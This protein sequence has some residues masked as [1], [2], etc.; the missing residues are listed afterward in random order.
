MIAMRKMVS[1]TSDPAS[2]AGRRALLLGVAGLALSGL[3]L[4]GCTTRMA[5]VGPRLG[6]PA[7][8]DGGFILSDGARLPYRTWLPVG[9]PRVAV[10]ALHG[11]NDSRDAWA[12]PGPVFARAGMAIYAPDQRGFGAAPGRGLWPGGDVL[13]RDAAE[14]ARL[15]RARHPDVPLVLMGESMGG[16]VLMRLATLP[17]APPAARYVLSAPAV[18]SRA[19]MNLFLRVGLWAAATFVPGMTAARP[20]PPVHIVASDNREALIAL[21]EDPLTIKDT[22]FDTMRGL[23]NLMDAAQAA[24]P[25]ITEPA[26]FLYGGH[27]QLIPKDSMRATWHALPPTARRAYYPPGYHLLLRDLERAVPIDDII[28]WVAAPGPGLPSGADRRA[29]RWM[30]HGA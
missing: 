21:F 29:A 2:P 16:A 25:A 17:E 27:D 3:A 28:A 13:A 8:A 30:Q 22:R 18:W 6:R 10:L 12:L 26:L 11:F 9:A 1:T 19:Q 14:M 7:M 15:V 20:P 23:V 4:A 24:A 5:P